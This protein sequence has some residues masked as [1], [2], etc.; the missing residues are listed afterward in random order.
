MPRSDRVRGYEVAKGRHELERTAAAHGIEKLGA[1][2]FVE[3]DDL[4]VD[5][6]IVSVHLEREQRGEIRETRNGFPF[7]DTSV[8]PPPVT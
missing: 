6:S 1:A 3:L 4:P 8:V 5:H 2:R 7:L